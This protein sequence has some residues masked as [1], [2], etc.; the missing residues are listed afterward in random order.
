[1]PAKG[2][3]VQITCM[4]CEKVFEVQ[5]CF[6]KRRKFCDKACY[7]QWDDKHRIHKVCEICGTAF[8]VK[9]HNS[10]ARFCSRACGGKWHM[11]N[12][13][14]RGPDMRGNTY[15]KGRRTSG[16]FTPDRV[17][18]AANP[19]W[20][21]PIVF[22]CELCKQEYHMKPWQVRQQPNRRFCSNKCAKAFQSGDKH[23]HYLGGYDGYRG[24]SWL[25]QRAIAVA[26]DNGTCQDCGRIMGKSIP[27]HHI[28]P[29]REFAT[30]E[31][32]NV[33]ENLICLCQSCHMKR[34]YSEALPVSLASYR[35]QA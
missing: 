15:A 9:P 29:Y 7:A 2:P 18:G 35:N 34:E 21:E 25:K 23:W 26:R 32:A 30:A 5:P 27:V 14:M 17:R 20:K 33:L 1:M 19:R 4:N 10:A 22:T 31:E 28:K 13:V 12:R 24:R 6:A 8:S 11:Q 3:Q 16:A